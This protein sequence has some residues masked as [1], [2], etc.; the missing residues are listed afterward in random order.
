S[1]EALEPQGAEQHYTETL[2]RFKGLP[3]YYY[4]P[5]IPTSF[6]DRAHFGLAS[7]VHVY[8]CPQTLFKIHPEFDDLIGGILRGDPRGTLLLSRGPAPRWEQLVK[9]RFSRTLAD[10]QERIRFFPWLSYRDYLNL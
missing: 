1:S 3:T 7:D 9:Q 5:D 4:K 8:V 2:V 10:V 6:K